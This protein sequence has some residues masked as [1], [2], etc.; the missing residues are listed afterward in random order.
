[1]LT[2]GANVPKTYRPGVTLQKPRYIDQFDRIIVVKQL[3]MP[4]ELIEE[5]PQAEFIKVRGLF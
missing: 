5:I 2:P 3:T 1:L 4:I